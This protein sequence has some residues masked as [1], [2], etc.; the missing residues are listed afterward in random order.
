MAQFH[1]LT[2]QF[3]SLCDH[4]MKLCYHPALQKGQ[5]APP[6]FSI[7]ADFPALCRLLPLDVMIPLQRHLTVALPQDGR[8]R[9]ARSA[10]GLRRRARMVTLCPAPMKAPAPASG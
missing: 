8:N 4:L 3:K 6:S 9:R 1:R 2:E 10:E 5:R 7:G